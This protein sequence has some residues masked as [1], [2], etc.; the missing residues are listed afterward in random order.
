MTTEQK[1]N[2]LEALKEKYMKDPD[3]IPEKGTDKED[4]AEAM[5]TQQIRQR[6]NNERAHQLL[7]DLDTKA[8][9]G[10]IADP[11][12]GSKEGGSAAMYRLTEFVQKPIEKNNDSPSIWGHPSKKHLE[13]MN[14]PFSILDKEAV[15]K[16]K[17]EAPPKPTSKAFQLEIKEIKSLSKLLESEELRNRIT[18]QDEEL[19]SPFRRYIRDHDLEVDSEEL[20]KINKDISTIVHKFKFFYNRPRPYQHSDV[21]EF[22]NVSAKSP[23]YPSG[24]STNSAVMAELLASTFP[25]H[26]DNFREIGR[27]VGLNRVISG[28]HHP[29]DHIAGLKLAD[30][31]IPL[32]ID[33]KIT[34]SDDFMTE[35]F[36]YMEHRKE[37]L[38]DM[39]QIGGQD[40]LDGVRIEKA[41]K[42]IPKNQD[43][44]LKYYKD[45]AKK[46][47]IK[48]IDDMTPDESA[49]LENRTGL[50]RAG[51]S[52]LTPEEIE[53]DKLARSSVEEESGQ[54]E[55]SA[56]ILRG[57]ASDRIAD[58]YLGKRT[59]KG[60]LTNKETTL[61]QIIGEHLKSQPS[62]VERLQEAKR[63]SEL[64]GKEKTV[65]IESLQKIV[66]ELSAAPPPAPTVE[67]KPKFVKEKP[68]EYTK[69][70][71]EFLNNLRN[72]MQVV[73][74]FDTD[75]RGLTAPGAKRN[76]VNTFIN[77][78]KYSDE[79][80][81]LL[82]Y[83]PK[84]GDVDVVSLQIPPDQLRDLYNVQGRGNKEFKKD[85]V[86]KQKY[87]NPRILQ[88]SDIGEQAKK[89]VLTN[90]DLINIKRAM[91]LHSEDVKTQTNVSK[92]DLKSY[93]SPQVLGKVEW[94]KKL[95]SETGEYEV[96]PT[97][98]HPYQELFSSDAFTPSE[99]EAIAAALTEAHSKKLNHERANFRGLGAKELE[100]I[101]KD[102]KFYA[103]D[104]Q[105][106]G[107]T[108]L[109]AAE[110]KTGSTLDK[111][112]VPDRFTTKEE[113][114]QH[115]LDVIYNH[116]EDE[117]D[118]V[119]NPDGSAGKLY[120]QL[121]V[122]IFYSSLDNPKTSDAVKTKIESLLNIPKDDKNAMLE[123]LGGSDSSDVAQIGSALNDYAK[124]V[125]LMPAETERFLNR[126][127]QG[128]KSVDKYLN[129][130][131]K[132]QEHIQN[133]EEFWGSTDKNYISK[134]QPIIQELKSIDTSFNT[135]D[136]ETS[137]GQRKTT[138]KNY[139]SSEI[140][141]QDEPSSIESVKTSTADKPDTEVSDTGKAKAATEQAIAE[142]TKAKQAEAKAKAEAQAAKTDDIT[143]P[144]RNARDD[145]RRIAEEMVA[146]TDPNLTIKELEAQVA[147]SI[148]RGDYGDISNLPENIKKLLDDIENQNV[149]NIPEPSTPTKKVA[150]KET[151]PTGEMKI[152]DGFEEFSGLQH[153]V[154]ELP[155]GT[156]QHF[157]QQIKGGPFAP[158]KGFYLKEVINKNTGES[159]YRTHQANAYYQYNRSEADNLQG[160]A[161]QLDKAFEE[162]QFSYDR[163]PVDGDNKKEVIDFNNRLN[164]IAGDDEFVPKSTWNVIDNPDLHGDKSAFK[165]NIFDNTPKVEPPVAEETP[166]AEEAPKEEE[167][168]VAEETPKEEE[169]PVAEQLP[170]DPKVVPEP[171]VTPQEPIDE[172]QAIINQADEAGL[173]DHYHEVVEGHGKD[174]PYHS[175]EDTVTALLDKYK[176][177]EKLKEHFGKQHAKFNEFKNKQEE[178]AVKEAKK[179]QPPPT[180]LPPTEEGVSG[181]IP[182][183]NISTPD[184][185]A[186][187]IAE[188]IADMPTLFDPDGNPT[189]IAN[190]QSMASRYRQLRKLH[191]GDPVAENGENYVQENGQPITR[192]QIDYAMRNVAPDVYRNVQNQ[193]IGLKRHLPKGI[194]N[195]LQSE[196][197]EGHENFQADYHGPEH[198]EK[199]TAE[200]QQSLAN[201]QQLDTEMNEVTKQGMKHDLFNSDQHKKS[202]ELTPWTDNDETAH[203][204]YMDNKYGAGE[205]SKSRDL[206]ERR[207]K[208]LPP[209][210]PA[211]VPATHL[212]HANSSHWVTPDYMKEH[213]DIGAG[214]TN[215]EVAT[216]FE[217]RK[218]SSG[219]AFAIP[220]DAEAAKLGIAGI[221]TTTEGQGTAGSN[222][223]LTNANAPRNEHNHKSYKNVN[224][225]ADEKTAAQSA[226]QAH[227]VED[228]KKNAQSKA[229]DSSRG[230]TRYSSGGN[231]ALERYGSRFK[232]AGGFE[233]ALAR[234][235]AAVLPD[236][237]GGGFTQEQA[238][239]YSAPDY[240]KE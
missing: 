20:S 81:D 78:D 163:G 61:F 106:I 184:D 204:E 92:F 219:N 140:E 90:Q 33:Q 107:K 144:L 62:D 213:P 224:E 73:D 159:K 136:K 141:G 103:D 172:R 102:T 26:A 147:E 64:I 14:R 79:V 2:A 212:W 76:K 43:A 117:T 239:K 143:D 74:E 22:N 85:S 49:K 57:I 39:T 130:G 71:H 52:Y 80:K 93:L 104:K 108:K 17:L 47:K 199:V 202:H 5:A 89:P 87:L 4:L 223:I 131:F 70:I 186:K 6:K 217:N 101:F 154:V 13:I 230:L 100:K 166:V 162:G 69:E 175:K 134:L 174:N 237:A 148:K 75:F 177:P 170:L 216:G 98:E 8:G 171:E 32:L 151:T 232:A 200:R 225:Y 129:A 59:G 220:H 152:L 77:P 155:D 72:D 114:A 60:K 41:K 121:E 211:S 11:G 145:V 161:S 9:S 183:E 240:E 227:Y 23:A 214:L 180:I 198:K 86:I 153:V 58:E 123:L 10:E 25:E 197:T 196:H 112:E 190:N 208:G 149:E 29:T 188:T 53:Q 35:L 125:G 91:E 187:N 28:L 21:E 118:A 176:T 234:F 7:E 238:A 105:G 55:Q 189:S 45:E 215:G 156:K 97:K 84:T 201:E 96:D 235:K 160:V 83:N 137:K 16:I 193:L 185:V 236:F 40:I 66:N 209:P 37:L 138:N 3:I 46:L 222:I 19:M 146:E 191:V 207:D 194:L 30:Q 167:T 165:Q 127:V 221:H 233:G 142:A 36:K 67:P 231:T 110:T 203:N 63:I 120:N 178:A 1:A 94:N 15:D 24:H 128:D 109:K 126:H 51:D 119:S 192:K 179:Q 27:E 42:K 56:N 164:E 31:I 226:Q 181:E 115:T 82:G 205:W 139:I 228:Y 99:R 95:N 133:G 34:K 12:G 18:D 122:P 54:Q 157:G 206:Q 168:P 44:R 150:A 218:D 111:F 229:T 169:T 50:S 38:K 65:N 210:R 173:L 88:R 113:Q 124:S 182:P 116:L 195:K 158:L 48:D 68:V 135:T 132:L